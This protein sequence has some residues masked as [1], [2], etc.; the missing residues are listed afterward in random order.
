MFP[1]QLLRND[2]FLTTVGPSLA[3]SSVTP[4]LGY[5]VRR[6]RAGR[7]KEESL[8][9][10]VLPQTR[11][12]Q[13]RCALKAVCLPDHLL[14]L[15]S[16]LYKQCPAAVSWSSWARAQQQQNGWMCQGCLHGAD[17]KHLV[18]IWSR[19]A[20]C[21]EVAQRVKIFEREDDPVAIDLL[22]QCYSTVLYHFWMILQNKRQIYSEM[23]TILM[24]ICHDSTVYILGHTLNL[25]SFYIQH[26][27]ADFSISYLL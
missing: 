8:S 16:L 24:R 17:G 14:T 5:C 10:R 9:H 2:C 21:L 25:K 6:N 13:L 1:F 12:T 20:K 22:S 18:Q 11:Q 27:R 23:S 4:S 7:L 26:L 19:R 15:L 3:M